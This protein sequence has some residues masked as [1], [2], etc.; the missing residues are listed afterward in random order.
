MDY[1]V[2]RLYRKNQY[3]INQFYI[4]IVQNWSEKIYWL[5]YINWHFQSFNQL[6]WSF[7]WLFWSFNQKEIKKDQFL[8]E[9]IWIYIE[10]S[11]VDMI[12]SLEL[13][14]DQNWW[15]NSDDLKSELSTI[16]FVGPNRMSLVQRLLR[17][18]LV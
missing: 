15:S 13:E 12:L 6:F 11:I 7:N 17:C 9:I 8:S 1:I 10:I 5:F 4:Q 18:F 14:S 2:S 16:W 3:K